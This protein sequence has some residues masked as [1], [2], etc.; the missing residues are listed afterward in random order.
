MAQAP[1]KKSDDP[2]LLS[3]AS[4]LTV[5]ATARQCQV[6][7]RTIYRRL[8]DQSFRRRLQ[9][10]RGDM[11]RRAAG[12]LTAAATKAV[13]TLVALQEPSVPPPVRLG[14]ARAVLEIGARLR[15]ATELEERLAALEAQ[16]E[17][18]MGD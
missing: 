3:L 5:A 10:V 1:R 8:A 4:G 17:S 12:A 13:R 11:V 2:L 14:A 6:S 7:T 9:E 15:E 16:A 18:A